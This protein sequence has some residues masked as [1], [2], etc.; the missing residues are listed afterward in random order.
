M[1]RLTFVLLLFAGALVSCVP[2]GKGEYRAWEADFANRPQAFDQAVTALWI[3]RYDEDPVTR[4]FSRATAWGQVPEK[5]VPDGAGGYTVAVTLLLQT[6]TSD[7]PQ[8]DQFWTV[9]VRLIRTGEGFRLAPNDALPGEVVGWSDP[10]R[11][12]VW[13]RGRTAETG[14]ARTLWQ[15]QGRF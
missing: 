5:L 9:V 3:S 12:T 8:P 14:A 1:E 2:A 11:R 4:R 6:E 10:E 15:F 7:G 13:F